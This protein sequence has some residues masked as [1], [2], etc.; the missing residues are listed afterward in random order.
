MPPKL[1]ALLVQDRVVSFRQMDA[2]LQRQRRLGG[3]VG[4]NL[5]E[6]GY[7]Q[8]DELTRFLGRQRN[9]LPLDTELL[10]QTAP[11]V[12][13]LI[14]RD[15]ITTL[16]AIPLCHDGDGVVCAVTDPLTDDVERALH[17]LLGAPPLPRQVAEFRFW[18]IAHVLYETEIPARFRALIGD[19]PVTIG[20]A[21]SSARAQTKASPRTA[22]P[23]AVAPTFDVSDGQIPGL[24]WSVPE[25]TAFFSTCETRDPI[26]VATLGFVGKFV[27]RRALLVVGRGH[28]R[29]FDSQGYGDARAALSTWSTPLDSHE[30]LERLGEGS[31][32]FVGAPS[33]VGLTS[34]FDQ[35]G[36]KVPRDCAVI[37]IRAGGRVVLLLVA[38][39]EEEPLD[40]RLV[41]M[42]LVVVGQL[43]QALERL[44][45]QR[46]ARPTQVSAPEADPG[47]NAPVVDASVGAEHRTR[48]LQAL[49][50]REVELE[51]GVQRIPDDGWDF[52]D[53][54]QVAIDTVRL[55]AISTN[56]PRLRSA[57]SVNSSIRQSTPEYDDANGAPSQ[58]TASQRAKSQSAKSQSAA[59]VEASPTAT[60]SH[61]E[62]SAGSSGADGRD[63]HRPDTEPIPATR[64]PDGDTSVRRRSAGTASNLSVASR[65][66]STAPGNGD[67]ALATGWTPAA[68]IPRLARPSTKPSPPIP[69]D[70]APPGSV[71]A[72]PVTSAPPASATQ[73]EPKI[74]TA[75]PVGATQTEPKVTTAPPVGTTQTEPKV[76][77]AP[78]VS[79]TQR[80]PSSDRASLSSVGTDD[81]DILNDSAINSFLQEADA[82][83]R[84]PEG[85]PENIARHEKEYMASLG[86]DVAGESIFDIAG[87]S[88][89][90]TDEASQASARE[91]A[92]GS[93]AL[94]YRIEGVD[95]DPLSA[96]IA[97]DRRAA[98][99]DPRH[100]A[101]DAQD[102]SGLRGPDVARTQALGAQPGA[103]TADDANE[104]H[105]GTWGGG[106]TVAPPSAPDRT[107]RLSAYEAVA[108]HAAEAAVRAQEE[109]HAA[110][111][112]PTA[113]DPS[114]GPRTRVLGD[115]ISDLTGSNTKDSPVVA[116][117]A[118]VIVGHYAPTQPSELADIDRL[119][120]ATPSEYRAIAN[121][122][123]ARR[124]D[125]FLSELGARFPGPRHEDRR[126][127]SLANRPTEEHGPLVRFALEH[128]QR[129]APHVRTFLDSPD[130][131]VRYYA[132]HV[133]IRAW[134]REAL[135]RLASLLFDRDDQ[136]HAL[137][138][139]FIDANR[140]HAAVMPALEMVRR[141]LGSA[142]P[143]E[144]DTAIT[145]AAQLKDEGAVF[146]LI[147]LLGHPS[148]HVRHR[149][150]SALIRLTFQDFGTTQRKWERWFERHG[151]DGRRVW[152]I[153]AMIDRQ[154]RVRENA[155]R[156]LRSL[157]RLVVNYDPDL[158]KRLLK[159]AQ[160]TVERYFV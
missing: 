104:T 68:P 124:G 75:P 112:P 150:E 6:L 13:S 123:V 14:T 126:A 121:D 62:P 99:Q 37:P 9:L 65:E 15:H 52:P 82:A 8:E 5:L 23:A 132:C 117:Q 45:R 154:R 149:V 145:L 135:P 54:A 87:E 39:N 158:D 72:P 83:S 61:G 91:A 30:A 131:D 143:W 113:R 147:Q 141:K 12:T 84:E 85:S 51:E 122:I 160:R 159:A 103:R 58:R 49:E 88:I 34:L 78:P 16:G 17:R 108:Q 116:D 118:P 77:T 142:D 3:R 140:E 102:I 79:A 89:F 38:D 56:D 10:K 74:T 107:L 46:R 21:P 22:R 90:D 81:V 101:I 114:T 129:V 127:A 86:F 71:P 97:Q 63:T 7:V 119:A 111:E 134:D 144:L 137:V 24:E 157:P 28:A 110:E 31:A 53:L 70:T 115:V 120:R 41:P 130:D 59:S 156:E 50:P 42:I 55:D 57:I 47:L 153:D 26:L 94:V 35:L 133:I 95:E 27:S 100:D 138:V 29:G 40:A 2:A 125:A 66:R 67:D 106:E 105:Q 32:Y 93:D 128:A 43:G 69:S 4:T 73:I 64:T 36:A 152:L 25:L 80:E 18:H 109:L 148:E 146:A 139:G 33:A 44:I 155:A 48:I 96:A 1:S 60:T 20:R 98:S 136:I 11:A 151:A 92:Q 76:T 19:R